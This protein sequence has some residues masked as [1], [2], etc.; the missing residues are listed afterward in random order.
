MVDRSGIAE[1]KRM[2]VA[3]QAR[4]R[5][6]ARALLGA[7]EADAHRLGYRGLILETGTRQPE[8]MALYESSGWSI[9]PRYGAYR[10]FASSRCY[11]KDL[12]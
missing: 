7:L 2:Y 8:A 9:T 6:V 11:A 10:A 5:G 12:G 4:R 1:I 3:P